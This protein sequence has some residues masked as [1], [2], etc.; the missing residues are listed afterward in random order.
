M[1]S[2][3]INVLF[4]GD[5]GNKFN[6]QELILHKFK[7]RINPGNKKTKRKCYNQQKY[8]T[9][10]LNNSIFNF[11]KKQLNNTELSLLNKGLNFSLSHFPPNK[12]HI[13]QSFNKFERSLQLQFYF[14]DVD[15]TNQ[16]LVTPIPF[17]ENKDWWPPTRNRKIKQYVEKLKQTYF[18]KLNKK[19][20]Y[21][22]TQQEIKALNLL[23][24]DNNI[25]IKK[26]DKNAGIAIMDKE[27]YIQKCY[28][29]LEDTNV[30]TQIF[31]DDLY[32]AKEECDKFLLGLLNFNYINTNQF[33]TLT[34]FKPKVPIFYGIPK[35]HKKDVPLRPIVSQIDGP[36]YGI[37]KLIDKYLFVAEQRV[38][39]LIKD[40]I[41]FLNYVE[42]NKHITSN[43]LL[44]T[45]DV[46]SLY[47]NIPQDESIEYITQMYEDTLNHWIIYEPNLI[48]ISKEKLKEGLKIIF[49]HCSFSFN[50][51]IF[52]QKFGTT[53]GSSSSVK[54]ANIY[55][56]KWFEEKLNL[57]NGNKPDTI[58]RLV[59]DCF[60]LWEHTEESLKE[61]FLYLNNCHDTIKF[62]YNYSNTSVN[63]LDTTVYIKNNS[64]HTKVYTKETDKKLYLHFHSFHPRHMFESIVYSQI[65]RYKRITSDEDVYKISL[66][67]LKTF[68][69]LRSY[70][71]KLI[72]KCITKSNKV[73][74]ENLLQYKTAKEKLKNF[75]KFTNNKAFVPLILPFQIDSGFKEIF[76][77][78][79]ERISHS[80]ELGFIFSQI[81]PKIIFNKNNKNLSTILCKSKVSNFNTQD[82]E[83][84]KILTELMDQ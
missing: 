29:M 10:F 57:Y 17:N 40:T 26:C 34:L 11:S 36:T 41:S 23:K 56:Y 76:N 60:F 13:E 62:E 59:D 67:E 3:L 77:Q 12:D 50:N 65:L 63:F 70:P 82:L 68:F 14:A 43:T 6:T 30:Y 64:L 54:I 61:L 79:W 22:L 58:V 73:S 27:E 69:L 9:E 47:T 53:M 16:N 20:F 44:V 15:S 33:N 49:K 25:I 38:P 48:P 84:I 66:K 28:S 83:N 71:N 32:K 31:E 52:K 78:E 4:G 2:F 39:N 35:V 19:R 80:N 21:N 45:L 46:K 8:K 42:D 24:K 75:N 37:N 1:S 55:M 72:E 5:N 74:R 7:R 18:N 51:L 81:T